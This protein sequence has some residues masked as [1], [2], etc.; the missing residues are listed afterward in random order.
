LPEQGLYCPLCGAPQLVLSEEAA[1]RLV[2]AQAVSATTAA[3]P[4]PSVTLGVRGIRWRA[5]IRLAAVLAVST[6]LCSVLGERLPVFSFAY[7]MLLLLAPTLCLSFYQR[8]APDLPM[9][10]GVGARIGLVLGLVLTLGL[11]A[12]EAATGVVER[13]VLHRGAQMDQ[14][15]SDSLN[16]AMQRMPAS[17]NP[18]AAQL[19]QRWFAFFQTPDGRAGGALLSSLLMGLLLTAYCLLFGALLGWLRP[20][21]VRRKSS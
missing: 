16:A 1:S 5:A 7:L 9:G 19:V 14:V 2:E 12:V 6:G 20:T 15:L 13:Y 3:G 18:D 17:A 10:A 21:R 8:S 11:T 4:V